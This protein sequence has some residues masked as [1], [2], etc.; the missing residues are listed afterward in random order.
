MIATAA[1]P[2][3]YEQVAEKIAQLIRAG[4]LRV[5]DRIPSVRRTCAQHGVSVTTAVQ[6]F[7]VLEDRGLIEARP[8]SGFFVRPQLREQL[9]E[10]RTSRPLASVTAVGVGALQSRIFDA[11]R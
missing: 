7:R 11:A 2:A 9:L 10:P 1:S 6:A 4:T 8:K 3:L 5:G